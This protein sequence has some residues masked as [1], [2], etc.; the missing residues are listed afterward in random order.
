MTRRR[1]QFVI[2][3]IK[4]SRSTSDFIVDDHNAKRIVVF[5]ELLGFDEYQLLSRKGIERFW[6]IRNLKL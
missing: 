3:R 2:N 6:W 4:K 5:K 1:L